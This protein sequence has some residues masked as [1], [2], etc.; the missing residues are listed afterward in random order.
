MAKKKATTKKTARGRN[1]E[2]ED[3][4]QSTLASLADISLEDLDA[5]IEALEQ[6]KEAAKEARRQAVQQ[7]REEAD[8]VRDAVY[9]RV[10]KELAT[11]REIRKLV[12]I[13]I[14]GKPKRTVTRKK[15]AAPSKPPAASRPAASSPAA[16]SAS[17]GVSQPRGPNAGK[18]WCDR[19]AEYLLANGPMTPARLAHAI[20]MQHAHRMEG[21]LV[22]DR[23]FMKVG[24]RGEYGL[25]GQR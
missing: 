23:R 14:N 21:Y 6:T 8:K 16:S 15:K 19:A 24:D 11:V 1:D 7:A 18:I 17:G 5:Q 10:D 4:V 9:E 25:E 20:G 3:V 22:E 13:R 12:D 2:P